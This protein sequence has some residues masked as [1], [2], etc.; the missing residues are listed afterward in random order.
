MRST[1]CVRESAM[2]AL[3]A[4]NSKQPKFG[5][6][7]DDRL[8][9]VADAASAEVDAQSAGFD[10]ADQRPIASPKDRAHARD[11]FFLDER[12]D[13]IIVGSAVESGDAI[14]NGVARGEHQDRRLHAF[15]ARVARD[16]KPSM[17]GSPTSMIAAS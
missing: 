9:A 14:F 8:P 17:P 1:I 13:E 5:R 6:A 11:Q 10:D 15:G 7:Q 2:P 12:F 16:A 4:R 3:R